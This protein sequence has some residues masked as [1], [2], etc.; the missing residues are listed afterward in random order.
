LKVA[1]GSN[2]PEKADLRHVSFVGRPSGVDRQLASQG[3]RVVAPRGAAGIPEPHDDFVAWVL[4]LAGLD[5]KVYR[6]E[7]L[8]RRLPPCL[9]GLKV[10]S[11]QQARELL[12]KQPDLLP[13]ALSAL[14]IGVTEF[15]RDPAVFE[16]LRLEV[17]PELAC[18]QGPLRIWS[19]ACSSGAEL[20]TMGILLAE[21]GLLERSHL[22]GTDCRTDSI[23][24]ARNGVYAPASLRLMDATIRG[25]YLEPIGNLW[26]VQEAL[27]RQA[28]WKIA[29]LLSGLEEGPW[30]VILW[31]NV[32][33]YMNPDPAGLLWRGLA[34]VLRPGGVLVV[35]KAERPP[36]G[37]LF[38][39][40]GRCVYQ[41]GGIET[42]GRK[43]LERR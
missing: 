4:G 38:A 7:S 31:R 22:L 29:N 34:S 21:A 6:S 39:T 1:K 18:R 36:A 37:M 11:K 30:D 9:R 32:A 35:G 41:F 20:F 19:A 13:Q 15:F 27:R 17:L 25:Q 5:A 28:Q 3:P 26:E 42:M 40:L 2:I 10:H 43:G 14:L 33:I 16:T 8:R 23:A 12:E 24:Q